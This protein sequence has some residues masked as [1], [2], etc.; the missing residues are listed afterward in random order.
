MNCHL[1]Y[2][3][4]KSLCYQ[5]KLSSLI[6][7][8]FVLVVL[9]LTCVY[10]A[11]VNAQSAPTIAV[12]ANMKF[13]MEEIAEVFSKQTGQQ[14]RLSFGSSGNFA[15]QIQHGAPFE[16]LISADEFYV[17]QLVAAGV[18]KDQGDIYAYGRL[19]LVAPY[20]SSLALDS[21]LSGLRK[22]ISDNQL[23]RFAIANPAHAPYG[24][25]AVQIL[26]DKSL[27]DA[28]NPYIIMGENAA[29]ATQFALS[30]STQGGIVPLSL[31]KAS[32]TSKLGRYLALPDT[33]F[34]PIAQKMV[35]INTASDTTQQLYKFMLSPQAQA[36]LIQYGFNV[37]D[38]A[39]KKVL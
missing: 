32:N 29:Q 27:W 19:A 23:K 34:E 22:L 17:A 5:F 13:A 20:S 37:P 1:H 9:A 3:F 30:G 16:L 21:D 14:L 38:I 31:A 7:T 24:E 6:N 15:T 25:R 18:T 12:S 10:T 26:K 8:C 36:I 39:T 33:L 2:L 35:L 28:I 11:S 4:P